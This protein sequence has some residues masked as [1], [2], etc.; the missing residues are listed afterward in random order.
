MVN[1]I[2]KFYISLFSFFLVW[3]NSYSANY[4]S[5]IAATDPNATA[6]WTQNSDGTA[7][8]Q[9]P[10]FTT[11]GD[12]FIVRNGSTMT[13]SATW[14]VTGS[15]E[16]SFGGSLTYGHDSSVG[17]YIKNE[18][19]LNTTSANTDLVVTGNIIY[20][21][22]TTA[23]GN[24]NNTISTAAGTFSVSGTC[25]ITGDNNTRSLSASLMEVTSGASI[26]FNG[27]S[28]T[29]T[30]TNIN[31]T[32]NFASTTGTKSLG[33]LSISSTGSFVSINET[34][35]VTTVN[36][37]GADFN[38]LGGNTPTINASGDV[39]IGAGTTSIGRSTWNVTGNFNVNGTATFSSGT[40]TKTIGGNAN[41]AAGGNWNCTASPSFRIRGNLDI[42][43]TFTSGNGIYYFDGGGAQ[44]ILGDQASAT[45]AYISV[46]GGTTLT[47]NLTT[48]NIST[49]LQTSAGAGTFVVAAGTTINYSG[50]G[51]G[52]SLDVTTL[53]TDQANCTF[54]YARGNTQTVKSTTYHNLIFSGGAFVKTLGG[55]I[56]VNNNLW[57]Q[58]GTLDMSTFD[59][60][61]NAVGTFTM[62]ASTALRVGN[63]GSAVAV[64]FPSGFT[65]GNIS[66]NASSTVTYQANTAQTVS[67]VPTYGNL[68]L[69]TSGNKTLGG[70]T[71]NVGGTLTVSLG[72]T[73]VIGA[74]TLNVTGGNCVNT[75]EITISTG[76]LDIADSY[77]YTST[78]NLT[79]SGAGT[80][81]V[82][83]DWTNTG[84]F[85]PNVST[86]TFNG[87]QAT[88]QVASETMS[89]YNLVLNNSTSTNDFTVVD[90]STVSIT[91][92][93][94]ITSGEFIFDSTDDLAVTNATTINTGGTLRVS[95]TIT[96]D[97]GA[98]TQI[99]G[100]GQIEGSNNNPIVNCGALTMDGTSAV[101]GNNGSRTHDINCTSLT[102]AST[103]TGAQIEDCDFTV[104]GGGTATINGVLDFTD[105]TGTKS[106]TGDVII[107]DT[108]GSW[109]SSGNESISI[110]GNLTID[111]SFSSGTGTYT[112]SG[113]TK[114]ITTTAGVASATFSGPV[115][116]SGTYTN[117]IATL[118]FAGTI[119]TNG[120]GSI[121]I[122]A[123]TVNCASTI[124]N[125]GDIVITSGTW[126]ANGGN[127]TN[128][129]TITIATGL[130]DIADGYD[131]NGTAGLGTLTF[132]GAGTMEVGDDWNNTGTFNANVSTVTFNGNQASQIVA[133]EAQAFY[134]L[135]LNNTTNTNDFTFPDGLTTSVSNNLT[136]T[137]GDIILNTADVLTVSGAT[138]FATNGHLYLDNTAGTIA[139]L[140]TA[141]TMNGASFIHGTGSNGVINCGALT[142]DGTSYTTSDNANRAYDI[143]CTSLTIPSTATGVI[144]ADCDFSV[145]GGGTA[146]INGIIDFSDNS[147]TKTFSGDV[148]IND[149]DGSWS[150]SGNESFSIGGSLQVDDSF[151]SGTGT[152]TFTG[153]TKNITTTAGVASVT[154]G[155][156]VV[157]SGTYT[158]SIA[159]LNFSSTL[160]VDA[161]GSLALAATTANVNGGNVSNDG[162]ITISTGVLDIA[163][164]YD[165]TSV[166][167]GNGTLTFSGA[168]SMEVGDDWLNTGTFTAAQST[169][170]FN[171]NQASQ[172]VSSE[173]QAFYNLVL[174]N[175]TSTNNFV[176]TNA[177]TVTV[178]NNFTLTSGEML[179]DGTETFDVPAAA[180][181]S[182]I[183]TGG[184]IN[185]NANDVTINF[186]G[187]GGL[188]MQ[189]AARIGDTGN[190]TGDVFCKFLS[191]AAGATA[192]IG[193]VDF[194]CNNDATID[195]SLEWDD[196]TGTK[197]ITGNL[198]VNGTGTWNNSSNEGF[199]IGGN[200]TNDGGT[201]SGGTTAGA[202]VMTGTAK[203]IN[204]T[205][206]S[207]HMYSLQVNVSV[208][209]NV[210]SFTIY[211]D[212]TGVG[213]IT[214]AASKTLYIGGDATITGLTANTAN[215]IVR[216]NG[217]AA[218]SVKGTTYVNLIIENSTTTSVLTAAANITCNGYL[219]VTGGILRIGSGIAVSV[220]TAEDV[221]ISTGGTIDFATD[222]T[223]TFTCG[224]LILNGGTM[225][226]NQ[227]SVVSCQTITS[228]AAVNSTI[229][230]CTMNNAGATTV[231]GPL[232]WSNANG[233]K[234]LSGDVTIGAT[235]SWTNTGNTA[236]SIAGT[237]SL[238]PA[239]S[240]FDMGTGNLT[241]TGAAKGFYADLGS[242]IFTDDLVISGS[243][244]N[245]TNTLTV[246]RDVSGGGSLANDAGNLIQIGR[247]M[248]MA[249][250]DA[251]SLGENTV[252]FNGT[253]NQTINVATQFRTLKITN[254]GIAGANTV[255]FS[256]DM[257]VAT[258]LDIQ[259]GV[260]YVSGA[261]TNLIGAGAVT[262][263][264]GSELQFY[265]GTA[266][267]PEMTG[268]F[269]LAAG[270]KITFNRNNVQTIEGTPG[271]NNASYADVEFAN[272]ATK[273]LNNDLS[274][275]GNLTISGT[276][277]LS[278]GVNRNI[279]VGGN[280]TVSSSAADPFV[281][282]SGLVTF[283]GAGTQVITAGTSVTEE[284][285][286]QFTRSNGGTTQLAAGDNMVVTNQL[287]MTSGNF[288]LNGQTLTLGSGAGASL[289][290]T[291]GICY[292]GTFSRW[293]P[294]GA[295]TSTS[296][297][298]YG[299]FPVGTSTEYRP[300]EVS[301]TNVSAAGLLNVR[302][303]D[304]VTVTDVSYVDASDGATIERIHNM[305]NV[306]SVPG[307]LAKNGDPSSGL[308]L[309]AGTFDVAMTFTGLSNWGTSSLSHIRPSL[310]GSAAPGTYSVSTG[311]VTS[312]KVY[313]YQISS[314]ELVG[315]W[316]PGTT[317]KDQT[318]L[319]IELLEFSAKLNEHKTVDVSW[320]TVTEINNE[321]F[322]VE[323]SADGIDFEAV[324]QIDGAGNSSEVISYQIVDENPFKGISYYRLKQTNFDGSYTYSKPVSIN[325][326]ISGVVSIYPN[327][328][329]DGSITIKV[330]EN[331]AI[332]KLVITDISGKI[333]FQNNSI[334]SEQTSSISNSIEVSGLAV[335]VYL[336]SVEQQGKV[337]IEKLIVK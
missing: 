40:G 263:A 174:N 302:H 115:V 108:D 273:T 15:V 48:L 131:Y 324:Q 256:V 105:N 219:N 25:S 230:R 199:T 46:D 279:T 96:Y 169:V 175:T 95:G 252:E 292:G 251:T 153:A 254:T 91:N 224:D 26:T 17:G 242:L 12:V 112:F 27:Q 288:D 111:D 200:V 282:N 44:Q 214:N 126:N 121:T 246:G 56:T 63:T 191:V 289:S 24:N 89:F 207:L 118:N 284:T 133:A 335:G 237:F 232:N 129:G 2:F 208:Q 32:V 93:L 253:Q 134:N 271:S 222:A 67:S 187:T 60:A 278:T 5:V 291:S 35:A 314:A 163:D 92:N 53:D 203:T 61:G 123:T 318:P 247:N 109:S 80:M 22:G 128:D 74:N 7:G 117:A 82:G 204:S 264:A 86:V 262:M 196:A 29:F 179:F 326:A 144:I 236:V 268:V 28:Y 150:S 301:N 10:N 59:I 120:G 221:T 19:T 161:G 62:A 47:N 4:Y 193:D 226:G 211:N 137:S 317:D 33:A 30:S 297:S 269:T 180:G 334:T 68:T 34:F 20:N 154:F 16:V 245:Y 300:V 265:T 210:N 65:A 94:T 176:F 240:N 281:Q 294:T 73:L 298:F 231:N 280:W 160:T 217:S 69:S 42:D 182:I 319:P 259:S 102:V 177:V 185:V 149:T 315:T 305:N 1:K 205:G 51:T 250:F 76:H 136:V 132:T 188:A 3:M 88:Q 87:T 90:G 50:A 107:N 194:T 139:N 223:G 267:V 184:Y 299:L 330:S 189:G 325:N 255:S 156:A 295:I 99:N 97:L 135:V 13:T 57:I 312:P 181:N 201:W 216:Y 64:A 9:P 309:L 212:L 138:T 119:T 310:A 77:D 106:F 235:G 146:T 6:S 145:T 165:Y 158:N 101:G 225:G 215:N 274:V 307:A 70:A 197:T 31:G 332:D 103:A 162:T 178:N 147:G 283:N 18:G 320:T 243:Y 261:G 168:G 38:T 333:V 43:G 316:H 202:Y 166:V 186:L 116:F 303:Y 152:Y 260:M 157:F 151:S 275:S 213:T 328:S 287:N 296:G 164:G 148:I 52:T 290:R 66:L 54:N 141:T 72:P 257:S 198:L 209:N 75:G 238:V 37:T 192:R 170:T 220:N 308:S 78:G 258:L 233:V 227:N 14:A 329:L 100:A 125:N 172:T 311:S 321:Y 155:G 293:L 249:N 229:G 49:S 143:N 140:G 241:F 195:G 244:T 327:P 322:T 98:T 110:A 173:A 183:Q 248:T 114:N 71:T 58:T 104:T 206:G 336:V 331:T 323:K 304:A 272:A 285:F 39:T 276:A 239:Q 171:G 83:D 142:M 41:I 266:V 84:T 270:S 21:G 234:T 85:T 228:N 55:A 167:A 81:E 337:I 159:T 313:K 36:L 23:F 79:F 122:N 8:V 127:L 124:T 45:I 113:A 130:L 11:A 218:Q 306:I 190:N 277:V 286:Y